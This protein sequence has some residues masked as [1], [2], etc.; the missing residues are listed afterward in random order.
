MKAD[1]GT[2]RSC[3]LLYAGSVDPKGAAHL[4]DTLKGAPVLT[5]SDLGTF[6]QIGGMA[7]LFVEDDRMRF[8]VN[9]QAAQRCKLRFSAQLLSLAKLVKDD[10]NAVSR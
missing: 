6:A 3:H 10:P 4:L 7:Q 1:D 2:L 5:V 9:V 8:A